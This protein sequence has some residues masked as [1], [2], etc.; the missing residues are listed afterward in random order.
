MA[1]ISKKEKHKLAVTDKKTLHQNLS[2]V[3]KEQYKMLR[4]NLNFV[5][6]DDLKCPIIGMTS[7]A[8]GE[9]K[10]TTTINLAYALA[11]DGKTVLLI[12]GDLRLPSIAKKLGYKNQPGLTD[13]LQ[14][15]DTK[16]YKTNIHDNFYVMMSGGTPPNPS[17]L[18]GSAK[19]EKVL[20]MMSDRFDYIIID[21]PPVNVVT[22]ALAISR[23][24]SGMI[25]VVRE[26][27]VSK[28]EVD[29]CV[30]QLKLSNVNVLGVVMN[31]A[32]NENAA[33]SKYGKYGKYGGY[34]G[35]NSG[36]AENVKHVSVNTEVSAEDESRERE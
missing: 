26:E 6:P 34:Y 12:D 20:R 3:A 7:S 35:Q 21:L 27:Y 30:R 2:F 31:N 5:L 22:D 10:S 13:F 24:I 28:R 29:N 9:G 25:L 18:L 36:E 17:E 8:R 15:G 4:T 19:M 33:Y 14:G 32:K 23:L 11:E 1:K 16:V